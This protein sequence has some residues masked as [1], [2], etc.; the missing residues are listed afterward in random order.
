MLVPSIKTVVSQ[1]DRE[2]GVKIF[3]F[4]AQMN[5]SDPLVFSVHFG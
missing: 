5:T 4:V 1:Y 3:Y 2:G